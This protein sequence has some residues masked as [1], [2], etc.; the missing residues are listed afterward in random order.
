VEAAS[1]IGRGD[2]F[3]NLRVGTRG[4]G[5]EALSHITVEIDRRSHCFIRIRNASRMMPR[6]WSRCR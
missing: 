1:D 6:S 3:E 5:A 4:P 2:L